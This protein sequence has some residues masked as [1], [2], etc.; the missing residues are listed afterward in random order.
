MKESFSGYEDSAETS[1]FSNFEVSETLRENIEKIKDCFLD[2][3]YPLSPEGEK[4]KQEILNNQ[5]TEEQLCHLLP[6]VENPRSFLFRGINIDKEAEDTIFGPELSVIQTT[7]GCSHQCKH[8]AID[9]KCKIEIMPFPAVVKLAE[10]KQRQDRIL[11]EKINTYFED[12][13]KVSSHTLIDIYHMKFGTDES[14]KFTQEDKKETGKKIKE[15]YKNYSFN[16][17][18][19]SLATADRMFHLYDHFVKKGDS[20]FDKAVKDLRD[21]PIIFDYEIVPRIYNYFDSDP[22]DYKDINFLHED[23]R[24][25]NYGDV[26]VALTANIRK[27]S[28]LTAGWRETNSTN[29]QVADEVFSGLYENRK[30]RNSIVL[31]V[32][33]YEPRYDKNPEAYLVDAMN[34]L[35][36]VMKYGVELRLMD[37]L[38]DPVWTEKIIKPL[39]EF[40]DTNKKDEANKI[41]FEEHNHIS[42]YSGR[43]PREGG[44]DPKKDWDVM[45]HTP[46]YMIYPDGQIA[47]QKKDKK[48]WY[49]TAKPGDR[50]E[51]IKGA[52]LWRAKSNLKSEGDAR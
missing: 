13:E 22:F 47:Y 4:L 51:E 35:R 3:R 38:D 18:F 5:Y 39:K 48:T 7:K 24:P 6:T 36:S 30:D 14:D 46:G 32:N 45:I 23:G 1:R 12:L 42:R 43:N 26:Y 44:P 21:I 25:A 29:N 16:H 33:K 20:S 15:W 19:L 8:C 34:V 27:V 37:E 11:R 10:I 49:S 50:P 2:A 52:K 28:I 40:V 31:T 17:V 41:S 9:A